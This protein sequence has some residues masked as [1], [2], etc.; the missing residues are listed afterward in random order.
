M[1]L[2][3][4]CQLGWTLVALLLLDLWC[5]LTTA[6][7]GKLPAPSVWGAVRVVL[8]HLFVLA[9]LTPQSSFR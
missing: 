7:E 1:N 9:V 6:W 8:A 2:A 5:V 3:G 4:W